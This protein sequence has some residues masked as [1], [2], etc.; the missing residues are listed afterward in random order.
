LFRWRRRSFWR[1]R[2][3]WDLMFATATECTSGDAPPGPSWRLGA[4]TIALA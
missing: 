1:L 3:I 2:L 4:R